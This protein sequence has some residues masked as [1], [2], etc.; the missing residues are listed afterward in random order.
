MYKHNIERGRPTYILN[1][2][3]QADSAPRTGNLEQDDR[4]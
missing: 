1:I 2:P 3:E 4:S